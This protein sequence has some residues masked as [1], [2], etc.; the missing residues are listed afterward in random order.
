MGIVPIKFAGL[1]EVGTL[2]LNAEKLALEEIARPPGLTDY[3]LEKWC[4]QP[5]RNGG[6]GRHH[7]WFWYEIPRKT[8]NNPVAYLVSKCSEIHYVYWFLEAKHSRFH[9]KSVSKSLHGQ[10]P[11]RFLN[12]AFGIWVSLVKQSKSFS[13]IIPGDFII[14]NGICS[15]VMLS[16]KIHKTA[17]IAIGGVII[18][19]IFTGFEGLLLDSFAL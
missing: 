12:A 3:R 16:M 2:L 6:C 19:K 11:F 1:T 14:G 7:Y 9:Y 18:N 4:R 8:R 13:E 5:R 10:K 17:C 15:D